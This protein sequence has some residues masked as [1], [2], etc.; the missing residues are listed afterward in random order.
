MAEITPVTYAPVLAN[1]N[2]FDDPV[3]FTVAFP[4]AVGMLMLLLPLLILVTSATILDNPAPLPVNRFPVMLPV[5]LI[6]VSMLVAPPPV[7]I[8]LVNV[9]LL[10]V[11]L[12]ETDMS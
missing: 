12:P 2:T 10:A 4:F 3:I 5:V 9:P 1:T 6:L 11:T 7:V 8:T